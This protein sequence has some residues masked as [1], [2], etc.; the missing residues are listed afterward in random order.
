MRLGQGLVDAGLIGAQRTA[1][2]QQQHSLFEPPII[3]VTMLRR[4]LRRDGSLDRRWFAPIARW[5]RHFGIRCRHCIR[6]HRRDRGADRRAQGRLHHR[7]RHPQHAAGGAPASDMGAALRACHA[8][9]DASSHHRTQPATATLND[10]PDQQIELLLSAR[11]VINRVQRLCGPTPTLSASLNSQ[12]SARQPPHY[13]PRVRS[14][15]AFGR[16][17]PVDVARL[18]MAGIRNPALEQTSHTDNVGR[19]RE[20]TLRW[21]P[22]RYASDW[23]QDI[24]TAPTALRITSSTI[25]GFDNMGRAK[26][27]LRSW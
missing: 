13:L 2:L 5:N 17:P 25:P 1:T 20:A 6:L 11:R 22:L 27:R 16:R 21:S 19:L 14:L 15:A 9:A 26:T 24:D 3:A 4:S 8:R 12:R 10:N 18:S 7:R 23:R